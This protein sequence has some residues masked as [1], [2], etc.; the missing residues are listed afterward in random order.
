MNSTTETHITRRVPELSL[1]SYM[2]GSA[3]DRIKFV[4]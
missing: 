2:Q 4:D 3:T 1:L